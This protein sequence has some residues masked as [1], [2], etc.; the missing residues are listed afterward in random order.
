MADS[1]DKNRAELVRRVKALGETRGETPTQLFAAYDRDRSGGLTRAEL[2]ALLAD[3]GV[4]NVITR[5]AWVDGVF[6]KTDK[7]RDATLT[8]AELQG[9]LHA[10]QPPVPPSTTPPP[11]VP[12]GPPRAPMGPPPPPADV[13]A[14][15]AGDWLWIALLGGL[16]WMASRG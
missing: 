6:A 8:L 14:G 4:G 10:Q 9:V 15:S 11:K 5:G 16:V 12:M 3:A 1:D 7:D 13:P 2:R